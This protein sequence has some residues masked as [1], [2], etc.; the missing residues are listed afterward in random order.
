MADPK[1]TELAR[2]ILACIRELCTNPAITDTV[3]LGERGIT[4]CEELANIA[5]ELGADEAEVCE[6]LSEPWKKGQ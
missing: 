6:L 3:W 4:V 1:Y 5:V 2:S